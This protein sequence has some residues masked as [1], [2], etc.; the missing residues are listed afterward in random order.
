[1]KT[2][3]LRPNEDWICDRL[4]AEWIAGNPEISVLDPSQADVI[5]LMSTWNWRS[6]PL[7]I[8]KA[9]KVVATIHHIVP[10]K[11]TKQTYIEFLERDKYVDFYHVPCELTR[12]T[13]CK[14][15]NKKVYVI[16]FWINGKIWGTRVA[17]E[18]LRRQYGYSSGHFL[19]GSFQR[20]TEGHDLK[21][22]KLE[23]GPDIFCDIIS[24]LNQ[25][26]DNLEII[27]AGWRRQYV[28]G[29]LESENIPYRYME[30]PDFPTINQLYNILDLYV[31]ASRVEGGP[32]AIPECAITRTPIVST[33]VGLAS[34]FL[35][36]ESIFSNVDDFFKAKASVDYAYERA[37][38]YLIP[39]GFAAF[40][41]MLGEE[42]LNG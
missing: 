23:K 12:K 21:S 1:M 20:D 34:R 26:V 16:P 42:L 24:R 28:I 30:L 4:V 13:L 33:N 22:P 37:Q 29:R 17:K 15:T 14:I 5:W 18:Q 6:I 3:L 36:R 39:D 27:L 19:V 40:R 9:K 31:V 11:F 38:S 2:F 10:D 25:E 7:S 41:D 35:E 8:L 32:Q